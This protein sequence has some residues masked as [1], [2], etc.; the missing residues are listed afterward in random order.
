MTLAELNDAVRQRLCTALGD[1]EGRATARIVM[2]DLAQADPVRIFTRGDYV[3][4][5]ETVHA[6]N[7]AVDR[8]VAGTPPQYAI[9]FARWMGMKLRVTAATLIPRPETAGLVDMI[10]DCWADRT[11]LAVLDIGTG[12]GCIAIALSRALPFSKVSAIDMSADALH[13]ARENA[14]GLHAAVNFSQCDILKAATP[15]PDVYDIIVSNP[16]YIPA[17]ETDEVDGRVAASEPHTALFVP[18]DDPLLFYRA[19][20]K[21]ASVALK[22]GGGLY[23]EINPH[24]GQQLQQLLQSQGFTQ[25]ELSRDSFGKVRFAKA[26]KP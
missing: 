22:S 4:E 12:S 17:S 3:P 10:T 14:A 6:V 26:L 9:G 5:P 13:V 20:G 15:E 21:Y 16:P 23:F 1:A 19:I 7:R 18:D 2:E 11:D 25:V 24:F 8:I